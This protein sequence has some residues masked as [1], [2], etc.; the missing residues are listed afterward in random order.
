MLITGYRLQHSIRELRTELEVVVGQFGESLMQ[1]PE[2]PKPKP[3]ELY[4][5]IE[6]LERRIAAVQTAQTQYNLT[7]KVT[8]DGR[9]ISLCQA[10]KMVGGAGRGEKMWRGFAVQ[11]KDRYALREDLSRDKDHVYAARVMSEEECLE[12][13]K[14]AAKKAAELREAIQVANASELEV[15]MEPGALP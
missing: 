12:E 1:Y 10:V 15:W 3:S 9:E 14:K 8:V 6:E 7:V 11:K 2:Q 13:A 5:R 4:P